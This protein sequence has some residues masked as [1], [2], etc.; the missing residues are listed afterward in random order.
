MSL[1]FPSL[2]PHRGRDFYQHLIYIMIIDFLSVF[3]RA[4]TSALFDFYPFNPLAHEVALGLI[5]RL[6]AVLDLVSDGWGKTHHLEMLL[7]YMNSGWFITTRRSPQFVWRHRLTHRQMGLNL[8]F[9]AAGHF[10]DD[11]PDSTRSGSSF[12]ELSRS[13]HF[14]IVAENIFLEYVYSRYWCPS[15]LLPS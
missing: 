6:N 4:R 5:T 2:T 12:V 8:G 7:R 3:S 10:S 15:I 9:F 13:A 14:D 1:G 11:A